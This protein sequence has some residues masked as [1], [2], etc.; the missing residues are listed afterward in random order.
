MSF[1][2]RSESSALGIDYD[3]IN[4]NQ[5]N[6]MDTSN[7]LI[8][9]YCSAETLLSILKNKTIRFSDASCLNDG[10]EII[11]GIRQFEKSMERLIDREDI[12][13][14]YPAISKVFIDDVRQN[15]DLTLRTSKSFV[16][17]FSTS[18]DS[19][20]QWR[21]YADDGQGFSI[22]FSVNELDTPARYF[23]VTY[24]IKR[25]QDLIIQHIICLFELYKKDNNLFIRSAE[26]NFGYLFDV[27]ATMKNPAFT[28]EREVRGSHIVEIDLKYN[29]EKLRFLGGFVWG[30]GV[31][32]GNISYRVSKGRLVPF[33]DLKMQIKSQFAVK[34]IWMGPRC[35]TPISDFKI[36]L[37]TLG[38][39]GIEVKQAGSM[40]R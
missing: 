35:T 18:G 28:D 4:V 17:C 14:T 30:V 8:Y 2:V 39:S 25:Q 31:K 26:A 36:F 38:F 33:I 23:K 7:D 11:W 16:A 3:L 27:I 32:D 20:S 29:K 12:P 19:L 9:H 24:E 10:E 34:E 5:S 37:N 1:E 22:G 40:Y 13:D 15:W 21:A 6:R